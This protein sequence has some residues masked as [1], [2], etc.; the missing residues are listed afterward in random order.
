MRHS[1]WPGLLMAAILLLVIPQSG[2]AAIN[3]SLP[4]SLWLVEAGNGSPAGMLNMPRPW[5]LG[6]AFL[7]A[8]GLSARNDAQ[9]EGLRGAVKSVRTVDSEEERL[10]AYNKQGFTTRMTTTFDKQRDEG[11]DMS[12][13]TFDAY[14]FLPGNLLHT[15]SVHYD[16]AIP[17]DTDFLRVEYDAQGRPSQL[18]TSVVVYMA[19]T[20]KVTT[21]TAIN[22]FRYDAQGRLSEVVSTQDGWVQC[23]MTAVPVPEGRQFEI[24]MFQPRAEDGK[25][26]V[27]PETLVQRTRLTLDAQGRTRTSVTVDGQHVQQEHAVWTYGEHQVTR[28]VHRRRP[29]A[30]TEITV[31]DTAGRLCWSKTYTST[32]ALVQHITCAYDQYGNNSNMRTVTMGKHPSTETT[33]FTYTYDPHGNWI[34]CTKPGQWP[35][36]TTRRITY[37]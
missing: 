14:T 6:P 8:C 16:G 17:P 13:N 27:A 25:P 5:L 11:R 36:V 28:T 33:R 22:T 34:K 19:D 15:A 37:Y 35:Q 26:T 31:Y 32:G 20:R 10:T 1:L 18:A 4:W 24:S 12:P 7:T 23:R 21:T 29:D 2:Q 9:E 30:A 3:P